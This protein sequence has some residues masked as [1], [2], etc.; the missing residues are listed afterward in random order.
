[1]RRAISASSALLIR[2]VVRFL[3]ERNRVF[4]ALVQPLLFWILFGAGLK[5]S[6][7]PPG[8]EGGGGS[9]AAYLFPGTVVLV[10][11]F[12]AIFSTISL[13]E[14]RRE[15]F[16]QGVL[17][18]P[19]PRSSLVLGK[20][21]GGTAL[22]LGQGLAVLLC[23]PLAGVSISIGAVA[24]AVPLLFVVAFA[25]TALSFCIAWKMD[26][27]QGFHAV[28]TVLLMP[29]WLLSGAFFPPEGAPGWLVLLM[30]ADPLTY[31]LAAFRR[32]L[33]LGTERSFAALPG[34]GISLGVTAL[35]AVAAFATAVRLAR[36]P[37]AG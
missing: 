33:A 29:L 31:G 34:L 28:M 3:R 23:A 5:A 22:A 30:R 26:S 17:A 19:I 36:A 25:L 6:F 1:M 12:T 35:F 13:I 10:L 18:A 21:L 24:A 8:S 4:G 32:I 20:V 37:G 16:L 9:Y 15:G 14:D 27:T 2:E 11:L 7:R